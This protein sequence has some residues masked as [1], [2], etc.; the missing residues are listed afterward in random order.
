MLADKARYTFVFLTNLKLFITADF[1]VVCRPVN[2]FHSSLGNHVLMDLALC[3][4]AVPW[5]ITQ[6]Y[7]KSLWKATDS[8]KCQMSKY[9]YIAS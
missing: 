5:S 2:L 7:I 1:T 4:G 6:P 3:T 8:C 9:P